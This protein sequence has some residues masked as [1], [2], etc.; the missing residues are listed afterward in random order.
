ML[1]TIS[2]FGKWLFIIPFAAFGAMHLKNAADMSPLVPT[3][4]PGGVFWIY[5]TGLAQLAFA[6]SVII[7]KFDKLA[8]LLCALMLFIFVATLHFPSLSH[9]EMSKLAM[10]N[11]LK[12][13]GLM[14]GSL[15]YANR[16]SVDNSVVG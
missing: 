11:L 2:S 4:L 10:N 8:A 3:F 16:F 9:L 5:L 12:D 15:M 13:I 7:G 14:G 1:N 6:A